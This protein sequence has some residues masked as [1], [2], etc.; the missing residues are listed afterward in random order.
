[1]GANQRLVLTVTR[2]IILFVHGFNKPSLFAY[3]T[4][5]YAWFFGQDETPVLQKD[6][7]MKDGE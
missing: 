3:Y 2:E 7:C 5:T 1:M 6:M 4:P